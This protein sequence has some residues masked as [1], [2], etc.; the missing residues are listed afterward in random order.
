[1][2]IDGVMNKDL[3]GQS[4]KKVADCAG[5]NIPEGT[6]LIVVKADG[7]GATDLLSKEKMC[8]VISAYTY[9]TFEEAVSIA[10]ANLNVEGKGQ[11][12]YDGFDNDDDGLIDCD[13]EGCFNKKVCKP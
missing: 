8:S 5:I 12:C 2:F 6:K 7:I 11:T 10:N 4:I 1:M 13:D 9:K 3:V